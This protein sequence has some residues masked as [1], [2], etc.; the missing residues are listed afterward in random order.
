M[1][2]YSPSEDT[3]F[4]ISSLK[5]D[6]PSGNLVLEI[7]V[8]NGLITECLTE[9]GYSVVGTDLILQA[10]NQTGSRFTFG[11]QNHPFLIMGRSG[12]VFRKA[13]FDSIIINPPYLPSAEINDRTID[14]GKGGI[15]V[16]EEM[17]RSSTPSLVKGGEFR[18]LLST[19]SDSVKLMEHLSGF[20]RLK[21]VGR[22]ALFFEELIAIKARLE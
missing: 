16:V 7:G 2:V 15:E 10:L 22:K 6:G 12:G 11:E 21:E 1:T 19:L 4:L 18:F 5:E 3:H 20:L 17:I 13:I 14:G 8:G 9:M